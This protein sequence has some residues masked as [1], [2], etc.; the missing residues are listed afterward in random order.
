VFGPIPV[1]TNIDIGRCDVFAL[2]AQSTATCAGGFDCVI[3]NGFLGV[4]PGTSITGNFVG[5]QS[6]SGLQD[7]NCATDQI[8]ALAA[9][10]AL[11]SPPNQDIEMAG[12]TFTPGL[13]VSGSAFNIALSPPG[14]TVVTLDGQ[15]NSNAVF[16]FKA[17]STLV[18]AARSEVRLVNGAQAKNVYWVLGTALTMGNDSTLVGNVLAGSAITINTNGVLCGRALAGT[19]VTCETACVVGF[20]DNGGCGH[21]GGSNGDPHFKTWRG[22]HFDYHGECDLVLLHSS[23]FGAGLGLDVH[24]RTKMRRDMA[25]ISAAVLRMGDDVLEVESEGIYYFNGVYGAALPNDFSGFALK[26]TQPTAKQHVFEITLGGEQHIMLK[27]YKD[28]VSVLIEEGDSKHFVDSVG[29]MGDYHSGRMLARDGQTVLEDPS[30]FGQEWQVLDTEQS[31]FQTLRLP[32]YPMECTKPTP[33]A[34][35]QLRRRLAETSA[36]DVLAAEKAC[37]HWGEGKDDCVYDVMTTGDLEMADA[38]AY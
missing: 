24:I 9:G 14:D 16:I 35:S 21:G 15:G 12:K 19:A 25:F 33:M 11:V 8:I 31:F 13:Y 3:N 23:E 32:Q 36:A 6:Q 28:F 4:S 7:D 22:H 38:G 20:D 37:A 1:A 29:L 34:T 10:V 17:G 27:T 2:H 18:T 30:A 5:D 26:H